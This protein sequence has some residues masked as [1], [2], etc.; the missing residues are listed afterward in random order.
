MI[1]LSKEKSIGFF[2][3]ILSFFLSTHL[4][5][6]IELVGFSTVWDDHYSEW[7]IYAFKGEEEVLGSL[8]RKWPFKNNWK[9][10]SIE[11][12][13]YNYTVRQKYPNQ[14][15][16]WELKGNGKIVEMNTVWRSDINTW[17][18]KFGSEVYRFQTEYPNDLNYWYHEEKDV[19]YVEIVTVYKNDPRD[20]DLFDIHPDL[21]LEV[22]LSMAFLSAY[23]SSPKR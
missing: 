8:N 9:E 1:F 22:K 15:D 3:F 6:Q 12:D 10:W 5:S 16:F 7:E 13:G 21:E 18:I 14:N 20:W 2:L 11:L 23:Y 17:R 4:I 19:G